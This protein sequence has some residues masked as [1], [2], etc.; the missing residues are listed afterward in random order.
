[1]SHVHNRKSRGAVGKLSLKKQKIW[2]KSDFF[3]HRQLIN[4]AEEMEKVW[5]TDQ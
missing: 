5:H 1:M 4:W 2:E 3:W